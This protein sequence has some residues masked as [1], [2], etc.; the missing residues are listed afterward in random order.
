MGGYS[1]DWIA[2]YCCL[3]AGNGP[4]GENN[5]LDG[6]REPHVSGIHAML[7]G[8]GGSVATT[9]N[10]T[11]VQSTGAGTR[12]A[13]WRIASDGYVY[14]GKQ[15]SYTLR[16]Q[17]SGEAPVNFEVRATVNEG[18]VTSG[19]TGTWLACSSTRTW[20]VEDAVADDVTEY[21]YLTIEVRDVATSTVRASCTVDIITYSL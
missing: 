16:Y 11:T 8:G 20:T 4:E 5:H 21:A 6:F 15:G 18:G 19:T 9:L 10:N 12:T 14:T 17:W 7:L 3:W 1:F 13:S 2:H